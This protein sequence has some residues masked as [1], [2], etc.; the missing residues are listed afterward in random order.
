MYRPI[1]E[2]VGECKCGSDEHWIPSSWGDRV[3]TCMLC[4][5]PVGIGQAITSAE[6]KISKNNL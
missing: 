5:R 1:Y 6:I 3:Y 4:G 2:I